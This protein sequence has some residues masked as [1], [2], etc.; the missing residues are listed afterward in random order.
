M[1]VYC[2]NTRCRY[3]FT[4][5]EEHD[6]LICLGNPKFMK[7]PD[8]RVFILK[9]NTYLKR[10]PGTSLRAMC[11][12]IGPDGLFPGQ[13]KPPIDYSDI[14]PEEVGKNTYLSKEEEEQECST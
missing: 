14:D 4:D 11:K 6:E 5:T 9:C 13:L 2:K 10:D 8:S 12:S 3:C 7:V 1:R